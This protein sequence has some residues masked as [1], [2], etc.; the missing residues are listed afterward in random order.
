[1]LQ[2]V[3]LATANKDHKAVMATCSVELGP[4]KGLV[5]R[6]PALVDRDLL[7]DPVRVQL[8]GQAMARCPFPKWQ[9]HPDDALVLLNEWFRFCL[10]AFAP[11]TKREHNKSWLTDATCELMRDRS[12]TRARLTSQDKKQARLRAQL[13]LESWRSAARPVPSVG[14]NASGSAENGKDM[15]NRKSVF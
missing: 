8:L 11:A 5:V 13:I 2:D 14:H 12:A 9:I 15:F 6:R 4:A 3:V 10:Q 1:M 7:K